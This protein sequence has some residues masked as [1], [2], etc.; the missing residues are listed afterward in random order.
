M[1]DIQ[2]RLHTLT[3]EDMNAQVITWHKGC[4]STF[5]SETIL[6]RMRKQQQ[7][8][9]EASTSRNYKTQFTIINGLA[10]LHLLPS[11]EQTKERFTE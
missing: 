5:T 6:E 7:V 9:A 8:S 10:V 2:E 1:L 4:Y 11:S 3:E